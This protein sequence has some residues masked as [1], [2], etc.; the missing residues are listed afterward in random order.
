MRYQEDGHCELGLNLPRRMG[1]HEF[2]PGIRKFCSDLEDFVSLDQ[3]MQMANF[4]GI[5]G[6]ELK[7]VKLMAVREER[8]LKAPAIE[9]DSIILTES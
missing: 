2:D 6:I 3:I 8:L 5:K 7:K 1:C 9:M 4:F